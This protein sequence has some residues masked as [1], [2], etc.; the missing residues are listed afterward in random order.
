MMKDGG[1]EDVATRVLMSYE[2]TDNDDEDNE[3]DENDNDENEE[4]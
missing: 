2:D 3:N 4:R 1:D